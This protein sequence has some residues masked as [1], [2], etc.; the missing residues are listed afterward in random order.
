MVIELGMMQGQ[1]QLSEA[2]DIRT[3]PTLE[4]TADEQARAAKTPEQQGDTLTLS[5]EA[6]A[7]AATVKSE[8]TESGSEDSE[9]PQEQ[10]VNNLKKQIEKLEEDIDELEKSDLPEKQKQQQI[11]AKQEQLMQ[12]NDQLLK[13][14]EKL[15][16]AGGQVSGGTRAEV[17]GNSVADF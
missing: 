15:R 7:L 3:A 13:A 5:Q 16:G 14:Q 17:V 4:K 9:S 2:L 6:R 11:Q 12:L 1:A 8:E 10:I